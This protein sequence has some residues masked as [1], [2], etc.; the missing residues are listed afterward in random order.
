MAVALK[1]WVSLPKKSLDI[2]SSFTVPYCGTISSHSQ[3]VGAEHKNTC[4]IRAF[5]SVEALNVCEMN[6]L[7]NLRLL[8][9][10]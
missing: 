6:T 3:Y 9:L 10:S 2:S 1:Q 7:V 8:S 4:K 5:F